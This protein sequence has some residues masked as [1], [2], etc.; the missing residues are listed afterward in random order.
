MEFFD[1]LN[2]KRS[3][4]DIVKKI[5]SIPSNYVG[6]K[7]RMLHYIW[8]VIEQNHIE[9]DSVFDAFSGS[10]MVS[11]LFK[12]MGK[13]VFC[14]GFRHNDSTGPQGWLL[15]PMG[16]PGPPHPHKYCLRLKIPYRVHC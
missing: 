13:K 7:R 8:D 12:L 3:K 1:V 16:N 14:N 9:F 6:S 4:Y 10:A 11:L 15:E 2:S 5:S